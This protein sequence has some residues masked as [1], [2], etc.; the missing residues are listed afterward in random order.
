MRYTCGRVSLDV[1]DELTDE[2]LYIFE[3]RPF[4]PNVDR[5]PDQVSVTFEPLPERVTPAEMIASVRRSMEQ[6]PGLVASFTEG[7]AKAGAADARTLRVDIAGAAQR[8]FVAAFRWPG[9][10]MASIR[11]QTSRPDP[12]P[13]WKHLLGSVRA[14]GV[15][16]MPT[17]G[18][19]R[20]SAGLLSVEL[21][22]ALLPPASYRFVAPDERIQLLVLEEKS[23]QALEPDFNAWVPVGIGEQ[24][25]VQPYSVK[26]RTV[27][28]FPLQEGAW[29]VDRWSE[30]GEVTLSKW[31][32]VARVR[33]EGGVAVR[34]LLCEAARSDFGDARWPAMIAGL[35]VA[36]AAL[37]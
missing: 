19:V 8:I 27:G 7:E 17:P 29:R 4:N 25:D 10:L 16:V 31:L 35:Q 32:R 15:R 12:G 3:P 20:R 28:G 26:E 14:P 18:Y 5:A 30:M 13:A 34:V 23:A 24:L 36:R 9:A 21:L 22:P 11:L 37:P 2:T 33:L 6:F 1:P